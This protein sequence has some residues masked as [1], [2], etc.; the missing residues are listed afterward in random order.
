GRTRRTSR[1]CVARQAGRAGR[2]LRTTRAARAGR[3]GRPLRARRALRA[4]RTGRTR[5][6][7]RTGRAGRTG[8]ALRARRALR[9][10]RTG[11]TRRTAPAA[12][13]PVDLLL[14]VL[15]GE[16]RVGGVDRRAVLV[17]G[18]VPVRPRVVGRRGGIGGDRGHVDDPDVAAVLVSHARETHA[19]SE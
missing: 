4:G 3:T 12:R 7:L 15:A 14:V 10:G 19:R 9:A 8:R 2:A 6:A 5:R 16:R 18:E 11:R 13:A 1:T 17:P